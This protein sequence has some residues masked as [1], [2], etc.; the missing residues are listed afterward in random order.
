MSE[1][2]LTKKQDDFKN[3]IFLYCLVGQLIHGGLIYELA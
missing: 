1:L 2:K 3:Q